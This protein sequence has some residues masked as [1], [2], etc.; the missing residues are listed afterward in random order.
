MS[1]ATETNAPVTPPSGQYPPEPATPIEQPR[2][3]RGTWIGMIIVAAI[4]AAVVIFE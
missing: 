2:L 3:T 1:S 4:V